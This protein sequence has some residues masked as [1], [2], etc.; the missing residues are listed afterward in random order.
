MLVLVTNELKNMQVGL[1]YDCRHARTITSDR[2]S[3]FI[4]CQY[5]AVDSTFP[6]Y[7]RLPVFSCAAYLPTNDPLR[8]SNS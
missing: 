3:S 1:C 4:M 6:K 8:T 5:S 2:G 7:P